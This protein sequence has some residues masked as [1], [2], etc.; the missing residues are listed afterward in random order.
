MHL[1][2]SGRAE[3]WLVC[4]HRH[5]A[6]GICA[7]ETFARGSPSVGPFLAAREELQH[8][9]DLLQA[10][11]NHQVGFPVPMLHRAATAHRRLAE[12]VCALQQLSSLQSSIDEEAL[13]AALGV[14]GALGLDSE[15][16]RRCRQRLQDLQLQRP[17]CEA[18]AAVLGSGDVAQARQLLGMLRQAG[19]EARSG[20]WLPEL[21]GGELQSQLAQ[22]VAAEEERLRQLAAATAKARELRQAAARRRD[23]AACEAQDAAQK[24]QEAARQA[25]VARRGAQRAA[26]RALAE[27]VADLAASL[28]LRALT[29]ETEEE[30]PG[31]RGLVAAERARR[32]AP[33]GGGALDV[34]LELREVAEV[35]MCPERATGRWFVANRQEGAAGSPVAERLRRCA[36]GLRAAEPPGPGAPAPP[37]VL[38]SADVGT[39]R[40]ALLRLVEE[41]DEF[42]RAL[43]AKHLDVAERYPEGDTSSCLLQQVEQLQNALAR[44]RLLCRSLQADLETQR[45]LNGTGL[46]L[47]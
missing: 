17:L 33:D 4:H 23:A 31:A 22:L 39:L 44:E 13:R 9:T 40:R 36:A 46:F 45:A 41:R 10:V 2:V 7:S 18:M 1:G 27:E 12:E 38:D 32:L 37:A 26:L 8:F 3:R 29:G 30:E 47:S 14:A 21:Q 28:E 5:L 34:G 19:L 25:E 43:Q 24:A 15:E 20:P 42:H 6:N 35:A 16:L 11:A